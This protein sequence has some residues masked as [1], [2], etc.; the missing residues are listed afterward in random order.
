[1]R[2]RCPQLRSV[3]PKLWR[4]LTHPDLAETQQYRAL[5][6]IIARAL[7]VPPPA[8]LPPPPRDVGEIA[9]MRRGKAPAPRGALCHG[10]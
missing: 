9:R 1:M 10:R 3:R 7:G 5:L 6:A 4:A 2:T 8:G